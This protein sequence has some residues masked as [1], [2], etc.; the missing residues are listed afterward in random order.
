MCVCVYVC[1][2]EQEPGYFDKESTGIL[3][4]RL[5]RSVRLPQAHGDRIDGDDVQRSPE[6]KAGHVSLDATRALGCD[7]RDTECMHDDENMKRQVI[8]ALEREAYPL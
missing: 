4:S 8:Q 3:L 2:V 1:Q 5:G 7:R 6:P